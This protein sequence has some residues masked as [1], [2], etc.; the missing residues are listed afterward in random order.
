M[1]DPLLIVDPLTGKN[2]GRTC[3]RVNL[4]LRTFSR[5]HERLAGALRGRSMSASSD[6]GVVGARSSGQEEACVGADAPTTLL[7]N[8]I[9]IADTAVSIGKAAGLDYARASARSALDHANA[10]M[11]IAPA[12]S[13]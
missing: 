10:S 6:N 3:Y 9:A 11:V 13:R 1:R 7:G 4:L 5:A 12:S 2:V 8:V